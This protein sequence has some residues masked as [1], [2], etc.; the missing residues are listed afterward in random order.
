MF[1]FNRNKVHVQSRR[2]E[3][4]THQ[5]QRKNELKINAQNRN[6]RCEETK[7]K[8]QIRSLRNISHTIAVILDF[9]SLAMVHSQHRFLHTPPLAL[10]S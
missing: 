2:Y 1:Y 10:V 5:N 9:L 6:F 7:K 8:Q 3:Y 4:N